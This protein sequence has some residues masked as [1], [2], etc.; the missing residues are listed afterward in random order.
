MRCITRHMWEKETNGKKKG[1]ILVFRQWPLQRLDRPVRYF[2]ISLVLVFV[3]KQPPIDKS[4][5]RRRVNKLCFW[6]CTNAG[7]RTN[8][9]KFRILF[10]PAIP[11]VINLTRGISRIASIRKILRKRF[12]VFKFGQILYPRSQSIN[13]SRRRTKPRHQ[14]RSRWIT[15]RR[16]AM[17][18]GKQSSPLSQSIDI[19]GHNLGM[20][21]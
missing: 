1:V 8:H 6:S 13:A 2:P 9:I 7:R 21:I 17:S 15:Q 14:T 16:L 3:R 10:L 20:S 18:I 5:S 12:V 19:R 4:M 11:S